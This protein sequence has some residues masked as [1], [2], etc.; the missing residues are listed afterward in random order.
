MIEQFA[1][2]I[3]RAVADKRTLRIRGGGTKDFFGVALGG[4]VVDTRVHAGVIDYEPSELVVTARAGTSLADLE[5]VLAARGQMLAFEP[6]R[7]GP[8]ST[9]GGVIS[10]GFSGP[11]R[12]TSGSARD[13]V[14][15]VKVMNGDG[16]ELR[17]GGQVM[18]NVAGYDMSR[19]MAG[20]CGTL[21]LLTEVSLK[22]L[23]VPR[24]EITLRLE[25][26]EADAIATMNRLAGTPLP[27]S[28]TC[29]HDDILSVR[30]SGA[31][32]AVDAARVTIGGE[33]DADGAAFWASVRDQRHSHFVRHTTLWRLSLRS[34]AP[35][36]DLGPTLIEWGGALRWIAGTADP[37]AIHR[38][39]AAAGGH[40]TLYRGGD[41]AAGI[42]RLT[43]GVLALHQRL[44]QS[45][46]PNGVFGAHRL[47][48]AF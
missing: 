30:L 5:A 48:P 23:P 29:H 14:L 43:P 47:H 6:P 3:R 4:E 8:D 40:A 13:Y 17:F 28:A 1:D 39:A 9:I 45:L 16:V 34:T 25:C 27:I 19:L 42:Q 38:A 24:T 20:S 18:K 2:T 12:A 10:A 33:I 46:D 26:G 21:G 36:L 22:V 32:P 11:R 35:P 41:K 44:K 31:Q 37:D 7:L 15:G